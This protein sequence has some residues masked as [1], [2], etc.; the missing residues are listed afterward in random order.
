MEE[1]NNK[2]KTDTEG[3]G[4]GLVQFIK[5]VLVGVTN[6]LVDLIVSFVLNWLFGI[7]YLAKVVGYACG[8][9]NSYILNS[10]W[11]FKA[12]RKRNVPEMIKFLAVNLVVLGLSLLLM[13]LLPQLGVTDEWLGTWRPAWLSGILNGERMCMLISTAVCIIVNFVG[14]KLLVFK[15]KDKTNVSDEPQK[16]A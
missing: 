4:K 2:P 12:E 15:S 10:A 1:S 9:V 6:T 11:T 7:Y 13:W 8:I 14:N 16:G 3:K 5:F